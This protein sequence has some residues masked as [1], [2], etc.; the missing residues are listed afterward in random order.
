MWLG[1]WVCKLCCVVCDMG[2]DEEYERGRRCNLVPLTRALPVNE[3][4]TL[5]WQGDSIIGCSFVCLMWG[6]IRSANGGSLISKVKYLNKTIYF[7]IT[8]NTKRVQGH[9]KN[10]TSWLVI[11]SFVKKN[12][13]S[14]YLQCNEFYNYIFSM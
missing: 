2:G 12:F 1:G 14:L 8:D 9:Y 4:M 10:P 11:L 5:N 6:L 3:F 13:N 7:T